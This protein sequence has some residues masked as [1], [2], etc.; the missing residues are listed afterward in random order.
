[1][2]KNTGVFLIIS[3]LLIV[4]IN[5]IHCDIDNGNVN[6]ERQ[7]NT[8]IVTNTL[9][10]TNGSNTSNESSIDRVVNNACN[11]TNESLNRVDN[12]RQQ[13]LCEFSNNYQK[14][15]NLKISNYSFEYPTAYRHS[16]F[17]P[18][19]PADVAG[20]DTYDS[21]MIIVVSNNIPFIQDSIILFTTNTNKNAIEQYN[22]LAFD[23]ETIG[24]LTNRTS[25][26]I[27]YL[28]NGLRDKIDSGAM[29]GDD[30]Y[31]PSGI[32]EGE[33]IY[34]SNYFFPLFY[35]YGRHFLDSGWGSV[36]IT[37]FIIY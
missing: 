15:L 4:S 14:W 31:S 21:K 9:I 10:I 36:E 30:Y 17:V 32:I 27:E 23:L 35:S 25:Y 33:I 24:E 29:V 18:L 19:P 8:L 3:C 34:D 13:L 28:F 2:K 7:T 6:I 20:D 11:I 12:R 26:S 22:N 1:M 5:F 37:N 16:F